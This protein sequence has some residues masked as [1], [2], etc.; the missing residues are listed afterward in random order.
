MT[1]KTC[2]YWLAGIW[3]IGAGLLLLL[4]I[5]RAAHGGAPDTMPAIWAWLLPNLIP[6]ITLVVTTVLVIH[7]N[8][9]TLRENS[10]LV[11]RFVF[12]TAVGISV[13]YLAAVSMVLFSIDGDKVEKLADT[14]KGTSVWMTPLQV[15]VSAALGVFFVK[16]KRS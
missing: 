14:F 10:A 9:A 6:F 5:A 15:I 12:V 1:V 8:A 4:T 7:T 16:P 11:D 2:R 13:F 3:L